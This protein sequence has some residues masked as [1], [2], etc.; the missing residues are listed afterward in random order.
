[1][2]AVDTNVVVRLI[3]NDDPQQAARA[4]TLMDNNTVLVS[5]TVL[6]ECEWVLRSA[7][8]LTAA[9]VNLAMKGFCGLENVLVAEIEIVERAL[10]LHADGM[11]FADALHL[12]SGSKAEA[13]VTFDT[14]LRRRCRA[15]TQE[16][17]VREP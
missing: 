16:F 3:V 13:F 8:R 9:R 4:R 17:E 12:L 11:D 6:M 15:S 14:A 2:I 5:T 7:Y 1:M 10:E